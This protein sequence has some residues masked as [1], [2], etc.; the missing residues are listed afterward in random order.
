MAQTAPT[1]GNLNAAKRSRALADNGYE[2][3]DRKRN[4]LIREIM[5]LMDEAEDLQ[6][7]I[8]S[9]FSEAYASMRLAEISMGGSAQSGAN[10]V[11]IDDSFSIRFRS[12][13]GVELPVVSAEPEEPSGPPYGLAFT[14]SDLDDAYFKFAEVKEL[15]RELAES[16]NC[17][18][19][20]AY[21]I[22]KAQKRANALQNIVI[23][24]LDSEIARI[25]DAL[26][27]KEREEFVRLKVVKARE[28][29]DDA[30]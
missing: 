27:E 6:E 14:S 25:S 18:Y 30:R 23:P 8:D 1:K 24:G 9:T 12:V 29:E 16:E 15:I 28:P 5:E 20:L 19:R 17:I 3:M 26:E 7:R 21:A 11:P 13:M 22:K 4:I 2:L 10:A